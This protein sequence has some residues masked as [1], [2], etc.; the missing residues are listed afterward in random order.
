LT[1]AHAGRLRYVLRAGGDDSL[2]DLRM[3]DKRATPEAP[4]DARGKKRAAPTIDLTATDVS[5]EPAA[6]EAPAPERPAARETELA[7]TP[8]NQ[9]NANI[10]GLAIAAGA[11]AAV[12]VLVLFG[13]W[14]SGVLPIGYPSSTGTNAQEAALEKQIGT[15][16]QRVATLEA[17]IAKLPAGDAGVADKLAAADNAMK[18]LGVAL[19]AL[20]HRTDDAAANTVDARKAADAAA[21]AV[22]D[23]QASM[24]DAA[25]NTAAGVPRA[26]IEALQ[27]RIAAL[28]NSAKA[29]R[30]DIARNTGNDQTARLALS[31]AT[32]RDAVTA[33]APFADELAAVKLL[34]GD[35]KAPAVLALFSSTGLPNEK[36]LARELATFIPAMVKISGA[37]APTGGFLEKLEAN[38][39]KLVRIR[40]VNAPPGDDA[41]AVLARIEIDSANADITAALADLAKLPDNVRAPAAAWIEKTKTRQTALDAARQFAKETMRGLGH[42]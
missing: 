8:S 34:G 33:G 22:A 4:Q 21:K 40:P 15:L 25:A 32:L 3:A 31:A 6:G 16:T 39:E 28:E 36:A 27:Q 13:L 37:Q 11:G 41:S 5:P 2:K 18:S 29:A 19:A 30:E 35:D 42:P 10:G 24:K 12:M 7:D 9:R 38:A 17:S 20:S 14:L 1:L 23:L 26:E